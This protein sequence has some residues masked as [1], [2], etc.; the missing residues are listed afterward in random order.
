MVSLLPTFSSLQ[1]FAHKHFYH[2]ISLFWS[3]GI[4]YNRTKPRAQKTVQIGPTSITAKV[5]LIAMSL[6]I[7]RSLTKKKK[8]I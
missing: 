3:K 7:Y 1:L 5:K 6:N 2:K 8:H 4:H